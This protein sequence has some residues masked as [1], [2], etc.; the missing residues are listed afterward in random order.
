MQSGVTV[1]TQCVF[2]F[3]LERALSFLLRARANLGLH[4]IRGLRHFT[5][6][7]VFEIL[8]KAEQ[9]FELILG[10]LKSAKLVA[11]ILGNM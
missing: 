10:W 3:V 11:Q 5:V 9:A 8:L 6:D 7:L 4:F 1:R 2:H